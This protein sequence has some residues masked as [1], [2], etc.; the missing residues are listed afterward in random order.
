MVDLVGFVEVWSLRFFNIA[1]SHVGRI[2]NDSIKPSVFPVK[3]VRKSGFPV[4][5]VDAVSLLLVKEA[6]LLF[7]VKVGADEGVS[8]LDV[9]AQVGQCTFLEQLKLSD[10]GLFV[11]SFQDL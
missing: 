2:P 9:I 1:D 7:I 10:D 11:F 8:A 5:D 3:D 4:K 6:H